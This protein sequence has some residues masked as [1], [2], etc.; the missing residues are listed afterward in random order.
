VL[1]RETK[2]LFRHV[3]HLEHLL[4]EKSAETS[5]MVELTK[6]IRAE[7][8]SLGRPPNL[9]DIKNLAARLNKEWAGIDIEDE[10]PGRSDNHDDKM[11]VDQPTGVNDMPQPPHAAA[12]IDLPIIPIPDPHSAR[13]TPAGGSPT[14]AAP[15]S[16]P[17]SA[18]GLGDSD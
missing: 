4:T 13:E 8:A 7:Y 1:L 5:D 3:D 18:S 17:L 12:D 9:Q 14:Q 10:G 11:D 2:N 15:S 6:S 16:S